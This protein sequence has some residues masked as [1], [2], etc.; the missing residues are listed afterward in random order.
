MDPLT[1]IAKNTLVLL[2]SRCVL[3]ALGFVY[4]LYTARY[5][6]T[7]GYG[8]ISFALALSAIFIVF[9]DLGLGTLA[10]RE[11][12]RDRS[13][14]NAYL[15][16]VSI[17]K[18]LLIILSS[19]AI[20]IFVN[21]SGYPRETIIV[22]YLILI[23][24]IM[25]SFVNL[26][27]SIFQAFE[28]ME[29]MSIGAIIN[30]VTML[31]GAL[32][33]IYL[34]LD[35]VSFS[36]IYCFSMVLVLAYCVIVYL[37]RF[38]AF[39]FDFDPAFIKS[40]VVEAWPL[41]AMAVCVII[42]FRIGTIVLSVTGGDAAV[43]LYSAAFTL[44]DMATIVPTIVSSSLFPIISRY[45]TASRPM[46]VFAF[47]KAVKLLFYLAMPVALF[48]TIWADSFIGFIYGSGFTGSVPVLRIL[49]WSSAAMYAS[50]ALGIVFITANLQIVNLK[51]N[52]LTALVN[53]VLNLLVIPAYGIWG[54]AAVFFLTEA[55]GLV[56]AV[57]VLER[58][59]YN[60]DI[61]KIYIVPV[62]GAII[63]G[64]GYAI[65]AWLRFDLVPVTL[66]CLALY[67]MVVLT[68]GVDKEDIRLFKKSLG[69]YGRIQRRLHR[70]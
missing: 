6:G 50:M 49:I 20:I 35:I 27:Y 32:T 12:S 55:C 36:L 19:A 63:A 24:S 57:Y 17:I 9:S 15:S 59:G 70:H 47:S 21:A 34:R 65:A 66:V 29:Y 41:G 61:V 54:A 60:V 33:A 38:S 39:R 16:N 10:T 8:V 28:K 64:A 11:I 4:T 58:L 51:I 56:V 62:A 7:E 45:H 67:A 18:T 3:I 1:S 40:A 25:F 37:K 30:S 22:V 69:P 53:V 26:F 14:S 43:G 46:F 52:A 48:V 5:L 44:S 42:Y 13:R 2:V 23:Y 31:A 68:K